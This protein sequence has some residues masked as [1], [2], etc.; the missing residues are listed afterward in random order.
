MSGTGNEGFSWVKFV[1]GFIPGKNLAK[2]FV[3]GVQFIMICIVIFCIVIGGIKL[4][5]KFFPVIQEKDS[6]MIE[7]TT[8][9]TITQN[10]STYNQPKKDNKQ[11]I[12][13]I[14]LFN[15]KR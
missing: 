1:T 6:P 5:R 12:V 2:S 10:S 3:L 7:G 15:F 14:D 9:E 8:A 4:W 11:G 13:N